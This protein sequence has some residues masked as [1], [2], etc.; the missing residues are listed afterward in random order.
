MK[1]NSLDGMV[2][3]ESV[4]YDALAEMIDAEAEYMDTV[5]EAFD[6]EIEKEKEDE[7]D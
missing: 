1:K 6:A 4:H 3:A 7:E 2:T 5:A